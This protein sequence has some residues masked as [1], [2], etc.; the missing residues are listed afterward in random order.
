MRILIVNFLYQ[1]NFNK[2]RINENKG[3]KGLE[4]QLDIEFLF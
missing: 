2:V 4:K 3:E 1:E